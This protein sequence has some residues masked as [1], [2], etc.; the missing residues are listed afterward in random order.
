MKY[1]IQT[2]I[3]YLKKQSLDIIY[4]NDPEIDKRAYISKTPFIISKI[5][6]LWI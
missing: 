4:L 3:F 5:E 1:F 6:K 2:D